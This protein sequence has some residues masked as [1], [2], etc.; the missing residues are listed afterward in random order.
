MQGARIL[1]TGGG[2]MVGANL[3][4]RLLEN[5]A[6]TSFVNRIADEN[7]ALEDL[8]QELPNYFHSNK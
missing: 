1:V 8:V 5:G 2:G 4:R 3:V 6:N 7:L